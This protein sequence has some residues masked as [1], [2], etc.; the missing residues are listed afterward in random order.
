M[1]IANQDLI[2]DRFVHIRSPPLLVNRIGVWFL[3]NMSRICEVHVL[4]VSG[5][6][7]GEIWQCLLCATGIA[8][9][10]EMEPLTLAALKGVLASLWD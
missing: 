7:Q 4:T 8:E 9:H 5:V 10:Q 2:S 6:R 3:E 1:L